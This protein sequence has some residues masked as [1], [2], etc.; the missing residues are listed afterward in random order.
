MTGTRG[1]LPFAGRR[2]RAALGKP[3]GTSYSEVGITGITPILG[4]FRCPLLPARKRPGTL[5]DALWQLSPVGIIRCHSLSPHRRW[6]MSSR[7]CHS[8]VERGL[9]VCCDV[10]FLES[11]ALHLGVGVCVDE[12]GLRV[13][14]PEPLGEQGQWHAGLV[15]GNRQ[16]SN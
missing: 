16:C 1:I 14:V 11:M 12:R 2:V 10:C 6:M 5:A 13:G 8:G 4:L 7:P 3:T 9:R 15:T